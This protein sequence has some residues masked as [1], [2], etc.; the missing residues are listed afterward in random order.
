[1]MR[2]KIL[3]P[4]DGSTFSR[5][6]LEVLERLFP[7]ASCAV[8]LL[9]VAPEPEAIVGHPPR[10][11]LSSAWVTPLPESPR[12]IELS[13]HPIYADQRRDNVRSQILDEMRGDLE[14]LQAAGYEASGQ[15]RFGDP[16]QEI[17]DC[18]DEEE[19]DLIVM[20]THGRSGVSR[21]VLGSV[22]E[23]VLRHTPVPVV[24]LRPTSKRARHPQDEV[25]QVL[26]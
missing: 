6:A 21:L 20:A 15:V 14:T 2:K 18:A 25:I 4:L 17:V 7:P 10:P 11:V 9:Q 1:M 3:I 26:G 8:T 19:M 23:R 24:M 16:A 5:S 12:D 13:R 22:A